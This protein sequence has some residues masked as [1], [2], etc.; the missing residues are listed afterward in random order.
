MKAQCKNMPT[1]LFKLLVPA[2]LLMLVAVVAQAEI[3]AFGASN[4]SGW[5]VA[6][7]EAFPAQLQSML[8]DKGYRVTIL[9]AGEYGNTTTD[10]LNRVDTDIPPGTTIVILDTSGGYFNNANLG[11]SRE[12]GDA[13]MYAITTKLQARGIKIIKESSAD[14]PANYRQPDGRHLMP[15]GHHFLASK[16]LPQVMDVLGPP[17]PAITDDVRSACRADAIRLCPTVLGDEAQRHACMHEHRAELSSDC[18]KAIAR[19]K[20]GN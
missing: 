9:N 17:V 16:L 12:Q 4:V 20:Q 10:M 7:A 19:S 1:R 14:I 6:A 18:L 11:L 15:E 8:R 2:I 5:N 13:D 3:V